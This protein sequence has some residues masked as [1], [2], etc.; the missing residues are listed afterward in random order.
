MDWTW[1]L[2]SFKG[3]INR[4]KYWLG[5]L[6]MFGWMLL[7]ALLVY[8]WLELATAGRLP[9]GRIDFG[10][11]PLLNL[12]DPTSWRPL[13]RGDI[14]PIVINVLAT[15]FLLWTYLAIAVKRLHDRDRSGWW[16]VPF[17]LLPILFTHYQDALPDSYWIMPLGLAS[18]VFTF[19]GFIELGFLKGSASTNL[20]GPNPLGKQQMRPRS[21]HDRLRATTAYDQR[22]DIEIVPHIGSPPPS[23][24]VK[25]GA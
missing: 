9:A 2:F 22:S 3:R 8:N 10:I 18:F 7:I 19:W 6:V 21:A 25:R 14:I 12:L 24:R 13:S 11:A 23:M 15:P 5:G 17:L 1:Y 4:A 20:F 16:M